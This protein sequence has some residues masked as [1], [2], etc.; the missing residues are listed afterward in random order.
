[1]PRSGAQY[2]VLPAPAI[3]MNLA[4]KVRWKITSIHDPQ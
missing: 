3:S 1:M 4:W 2:P